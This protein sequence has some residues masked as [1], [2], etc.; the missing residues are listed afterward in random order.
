MA[1]SLSLDPLVTS[2]AGTPIVTHLSSST[3][4]SFYVTRQTLD[5][6]KELTGL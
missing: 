6:A 4:P 2:E 3:S 5:S 1:L